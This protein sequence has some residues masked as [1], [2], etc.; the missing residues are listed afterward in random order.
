MTAPTS[1]VPRCLVCGSTASKQRY[2]ITRFRV[3]SCLDCDQIYLDPL[4]TEDEIRALFENLYT[5]GDGSVPELKD[6]YGFCFDDEPDNP[7]VQQYEEWL[8][9]IEAVCPPGRVL[10]VGCGTGLFLSVARR[11]G[12]PCGWPSGG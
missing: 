1:D 2:R 5:V 8:E 11:R 3:I 6:Y 9:K 4:P 7:L 12:W 10:D